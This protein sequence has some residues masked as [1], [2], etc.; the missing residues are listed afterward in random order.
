M[1]PRLELNLYGQSAAP[2]A[3]PRWR[4]P[5][6][7][8]FEQWAAPAVAPEREEEQERS[9]VPV[10]VLLGVA[11]L[12]QY[13]QLAIGPV[14]DFLVEGN[15][16]QRPAW[17]GF[18][19]VKQWGL[20]VLMLLVLRARED[21]L[22]GI[23]FPRLD[24]RRIILALAAVGFFIGAALVRTAGPNADP[25]M[26]PTEPAERLLL[27][28]LAVTTAI[29]EETFFRGFAVV[30]TY[31]WSRFLLLAVLFPAVI[32]ASGHAYLSWLNV[33][34]AFGAAVGFSLLFMWRRDLYWPMLIHFVINVLDLLR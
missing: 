31:R 5:W 7:E 24:A 21:S 25:W 17:M 29:V 3:A 33:V 20:F 6:V 30:W 27:V 19:I 26:V 22:A 18:T 23:G 12:V 14:H 28:A 34:F 16:L 32:F 8:A 2:P 1:S 15:P 9:F 11:L 4:P 13:A 10:G